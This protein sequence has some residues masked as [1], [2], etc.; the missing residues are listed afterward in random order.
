MKILNLTQHK[1]TPEQVDSGVVDLGESQRQELVKL[2]TFD[3]LPTEEE[4]FVCAIQIAQIAHEERATRVMIGGAP[5]LMPY[6][7]DTLK[8]RGIAPLYAFSKRESVE[9]KTQDG[10]T[11]KVSIFRH[12]GFIAAR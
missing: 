5:Y 9:E 12:K 4:L 11:R 6:L 7:E 8:E 10:G 1:A 3:H 2:L